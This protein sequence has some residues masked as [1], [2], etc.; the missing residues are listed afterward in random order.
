MVLLIPLA[1]S[2][3][4]VPMEPITMTNA[5]NVSLLKS[6]EIP[7]YRKGRVSQSSLAFSP[8]G[9]LLAC[10]AG[11]K[12]AVVGKHDSPVWEL[13][14]SP[15][16]CCLV[17]CSLQN[18]IRLWDVG[19]RKMA[20]SHVGD[21]AYLSAVFSPDGKTIAYGSLAGKS[22]LLDAVTGRELAV[23]VMGIGHIGDVSFSPSGKY[24]ATGTDDDVIRVWDTGDMKEEAVLAGHS[25]FVNGVAFSTKGGE[26][27]LASSSHDRTLRL[28]DPV[29]KR[30]LATLEGHEAEV[31]RVA[32]S[33]DGTM[34]ASAG[35]DGMI[36][37]WGIP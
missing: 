36:R 33:P 2:G 6:L 16:G 19:E 27:L 10:A 8:D 5:G 25:G 11:K 20:W 31:L 1:S 32:F 29:S 30:C 37:I 17:S 23:F 14:F 34:L 28:W 26:L 13:D 4:V 12:I 15:D 24:L 21:G 7:G 3:K 22:G 35:W 18:D 9:T